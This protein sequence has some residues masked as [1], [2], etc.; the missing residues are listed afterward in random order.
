[1]L[2]SAP[3]ENIFSLYGKTYEYPHSPTVGKVQNW[4]FEYRLM[5]LPNKSLHVAKIFV[6]QE[7]IAALNRQHHWRLNS[8]H[9]K[10][11][12]SQIT[13]TLGENN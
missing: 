11:Q 1:M 7:G 13:N 6:E 9:G 3:L 5:T 8:S 12:H 10:R 2:Q 4:D